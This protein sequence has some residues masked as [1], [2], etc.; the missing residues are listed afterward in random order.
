MDLIVELL[1][2]GLTVEI[3]PHYGNIDGYYASVFR[4]NL[5]LECGECE[6]CGYMDWEDAGHGKTPEEAL[7]NGV[8]VYNGVDTPTQPLELVK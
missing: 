5:A 1:V 7:K 8:D 2:S 3:G 4:A 6:H